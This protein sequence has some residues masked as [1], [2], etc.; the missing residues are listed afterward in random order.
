MKI[1]KAILLEN[2]NFNFLNQT[3]HNCE[4]SSKT[5]NYLEIYARELLDKGYKRD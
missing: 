1:F 5:K 2:E 4:G 3:T